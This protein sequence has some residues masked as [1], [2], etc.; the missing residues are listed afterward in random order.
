MEDRIIKTYN[1]YKNI[2]EPSDLIAVQKDSFRELIDN[3]IQE[4]F[5]DISPIRSKDGR[6]SIYF[7][8]GTRTAAENHLT[9]RLQPPE[10]P[11][12]ECIEKRMTY[13]GTVYTDVL[14]R[15]N[16]HGKVWKTGI[17]LTD[18][19]FMTPQGSFIISG[20]EK[21]VLTQLV[22]SPGIY[23]SITRD[24]LTGRPGQ[25]AKIVPDKGTYIE[26]YANAERDILVQYDR[27]LIIPLSAFMRIMSYEEDGTGTTPFT[28]CAD[29][30][31][32]DVFEKE[33]GKASET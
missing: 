1:R 15:D 24:E 10:Y 21:V 23:Y 18:L 33:C 16:Q 11:I 31:I 25:H 2:F 32:F 28:D 30:E 8:D 3:G 29:R 6:F 17:C 13:C 26:I 27:R 7:P 14:M 5:R 19:P 20:T 12:E 9:W 22:K 4:L